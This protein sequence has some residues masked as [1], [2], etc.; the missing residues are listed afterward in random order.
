MAQQKDAGLKTRDRIGV[1]FYGDEKA[2]FFDS[3]I[4]GIKAVLPSVKAEPELVIGFSPMNAAAQISMIDEMMKKPLKGLIISPIDDEKVAERLKALSVNG[5]PVVTVHT[6]IADSGRIA[7]V[8][9]DPYKAGR[10]AAAQMCLLCEPKTEVGIV[11]GFHRI[12]GHELRIKGFMDYLA[13]NDKALTVECIGECR[14]EDY[15]AY[16]LVQ[17]IQSDHPGISAFFFATTGGVYGGCKG[18][19]QM[20]TRLSFH[21]VTFDVFKAT[22]EF[23]RKGLI[24]CAVYQN[25]KHQ[26]ALALRILTNKIYSNEDP[27]KEINLSELSI[28]TAECL[29][30]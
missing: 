29:Y 3:V 8:G 14:D 22:R 7:Y 16:E 13:E 9:T 11:T 18:I 2:D 17:K 25:P 19:W 10:A 26:G 24:D 6:D 12:K 1:L 30:L 28:K 5:I 15:K 27:K 23:M 20:T 21:V 4:E